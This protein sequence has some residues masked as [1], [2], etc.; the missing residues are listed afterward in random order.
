MKINKHL[1]QAFVDKIESTGKVEISSEKAIGYLHEVIENLNRPPEDFEEYEFQFSQVA[2]LDVNKFYEDDEGQTAPAGN[3]LES[4]NE[5]KTVNEKFSADNKTL[6]DEISQN[7]KVT[8][9]QIH[10]NKK[11]LSIKKHVSI[12]QRFM[13]VNELFGGDT[14][15]FNTALDGLEVMENYEN[16]IE[17]LVNNYAKKNEWVMDSDEVVEFLAVLNKRFD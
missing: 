15:A 9:A 11:I 8:I 2:P 14:T 17:F 5:L 13:F 7:D 1:Y 10:Q 12:N 4:G 6:L 16:A 3:D